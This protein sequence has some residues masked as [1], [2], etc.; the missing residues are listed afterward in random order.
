MPGEASKRK[1]KMSI[2]SFTPVELGRKRVINAKFLITAIEV[3]FIS[4]RPRAE[5]K[6]IG[7]RLGLSEKTAVTEE[8]DY[9]KQKT[10]NEI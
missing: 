9:K 7:C 3:S 4:D 6:I 5:G 8:R 2:D 10:H 1:C